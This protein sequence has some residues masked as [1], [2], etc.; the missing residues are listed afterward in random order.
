MT[1]PETRWRQ[2]RQLTMKC[3][4]TM[5]LR[6]IAI[7]LPYRPFILGRCEMFVVFRFSTHSWCA[8]SFNFSGADDDT[9]RRKPASSYDRGYST[10]IFVQG[11]P[12]EVAISHPLWNIEKVVSWKSVDDS[13]VHIEKT[14]NK[15]ETKTV[16]EVKTFVSSLSGVAPKVSPQIV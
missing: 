8:F 6:Y 15:K 9:K 5:K 16:D 3:D 11:L 10:P 13:H 1:E 4:S 12:L 14:R 7:F 2:R